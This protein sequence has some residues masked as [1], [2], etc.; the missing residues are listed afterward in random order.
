MSCFPDGIEEIAELS[1]DLR[2][3][4]DSFSDTSSSSSSNEKSKNNDIKNVETDI[5]SAIPLK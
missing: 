5:D 1:D 2:C 4:S 3:D